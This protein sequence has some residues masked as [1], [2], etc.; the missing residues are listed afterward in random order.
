MM[1]WIRPRS[2]SIIKAVEIGWEILNSGG[3]ALDAVEKAV[4]W[5]E[6]DPLFDAGTG[7]SSQC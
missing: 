5:L 2:Q 7:K 4:N 6:D 3:S 1:H